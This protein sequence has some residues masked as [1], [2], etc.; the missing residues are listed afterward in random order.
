[1][2]CSILSLMAVLCALSAD[3]SWSQS[4]TEN[5]V[6][7]RT[8]KVKGAS[9]ESG[10][11]YWGTPLQVQTQISYLDGL[12]KP[13]QTVIVSGNPNQKDLATA[14][15]Y[16]SV[17][18]PEKNYLPVSQTPADGTLKAVNTSYY[19]NV[20]TENVGSPT[21][22]AWTQTIYDQ[23]PLARKV[24]EKAPGIAADAKGRRMKYMVY[25][26]DKHQSVVRYFLNAN[27][28]L[29]VSNVYADSTL[30]VLETRDEND[31]MVEEFTDRNGRVILK[32][33]GGQEYTYYVYNEKGQ[34]VYVL[35]PQFQEG[36]ELLA[37]KL[38]NFAFQYTYNAKGLV[39]SKRVPG[40]GTS[41]LSYDD[42][43]RLEYLVDAKS[44]RFYYKYDDLNRQTEAGT[45]MKGSSEKPFLKT[46]YDDYTGITTEFNNSVFNLT[47]DDHY[48][49]SPK[50]DSKK[51]LVT[52][53]TAKVLDGSSTETWINT[54]MFYDKKGR[55]VQKH[56]TIPQLG[57]QGREVV[58]YKLDFVGNIL[59]E[60]TEQFTNLVNYRLDK[61]FVYD[62][63]N[64]LRR[65]K[66]TLY[67]VEGDVA[68][69]KKTYKHV[70]N[71]YNEIGL[72]GKKFFHKPVPA[73]SASTYMQE[74][75]YKYTPRSWVS[76]VTNNA[77]KRY[78]LALNYNVNGNISNFS[79]QTQGFAGS[80]GTI[81][82]DESNR[83]SEAS[84]PT[85]K[86]IGIKYDKN[87]NITKLKREGP[88]TDDLTYNYNGNG[89][90]LTEIVN[91]GGNSVGVKSG[92]SSFGYDNNGNLISDGNKGAVIAYNILNLPSQVSRSNPS[93]SVIY[94]YDGEGNKLQ[95]DAVGSITVYA[96]G[97]EYKTD[98]TLL[99]IGLEE[100]QL[101]RTNAGAYELNYYLQDHLGNVR[102]VLKED[103]TVLQETEYYAFGLPIIKNGNATSNKYLFNG[104]EIQPEI[105]VFDFHARMYDASIG[106][107]FQVDPLAE[108]YYSWS[109]YGWVMNNPLKLRDPTGMF[110]THTD[111][112]GVVVAVYDDGDL[113][114]YK[115]EGDTKE[116]KAS[117]AKEYSKKETSA[118]GE[119]MGESLHSLSFANQSVYNE[120]GKVV[121]QSG[122]KIDFG[123]N[124]LTRE[125]ENIIRSSTSV[126][127]YALKARSNH[128]WDL[129]SQVDNGSLLHG[130][131]AS[132]RDAGNFA[133]GAIAASSAMEPVV[134]FGFGA[135]NLTG[136]KIFP[137]AALTL[138]TGLLTLAQPAV[139]MTAGYLIGRF[140]E[141]RLSQRSIDIGKRF[142][143]NRK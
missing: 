13:K 61:V 7:T 70:A 36:N 99:R 51:G 52:Q 8:Y 63:Q 69:V 48:I 53:I 138:A 89:N 98:G 26:N 20:G 27:G 121:E 67:E 33:V 40:Q 137:T 117:V 35:Q 104:K 24:E 122:M 57:S 108:N 129:K 37:N 126:V 135:Y 107:S 127:E 28:S 83:I 90:R 111:E 49:G 79:W 88:A 50:A 106:R 102:M 109:P 25:S 2:K 66:H 125:V 110:S 123:S 91:S 81:S 139:G 100:G 55:L 82:Y 85:Y 60:R 5:Y 78:Q 80:F 133:A 97:F 103:G 15:S 39:V 140:G 47:D 4:A 116:A 84:G 21:T 72:L 17:F 3:K 19:N 86:E 30:T 75:N 76:G 43:D 31:K 132:P 113:G 96:S 73:T 114:V 18:L 42:R 131:Y 41:I 115:H 64:R 92:T 16:N 45:G 94:L 141:D 54:V 22:F 9:I 12:G 32:R 134:Q 58:T 29:N 44:Q 87:G 6:L 120:T 59:E 71:I 56:R 112:N 93:R 10:T 62:H 128:E 143:N 65:A 95:M 105:G 11:N 124:R 38:N 119:K 101:V 34:L 1:M 46:K 142:I 14:T 136:N 68:T 130:R 77:G 74:L 23:S 118:G